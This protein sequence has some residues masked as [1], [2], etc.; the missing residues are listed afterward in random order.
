VKKIEIENIKRMAAEK[1]VAGLVEVLRYGSW[2]R[3]SL[4]LELRWQAA[5]ALGRLGDAR[6]LAPL[7][8]ALQDKN[9]S[10]R[11]NAAEALGEI[12]DS[13]AVPCLIEA[14]GDKDDYPVRCA[15]EALGKLGDETAVEHLVPFLKHDPRSEVTEAAAKSLEKLGW[16][17]KDDEEKA[18][19]L[20]AKRNWDELAKLGKAAVPP[21]IWATEIDTGSL[22]VRAA[23]TLGEI[24]DPRAVKPIIRAWRADWDPSSQFNVKLA[25]YSISD[26]AAV[27]PLIEALRG[28]G[29]SVYGR[30]L[31][32]EALGRI[33][34]S[35]AVG[36]L[37]EALKDEDKD[38][39][40]KAAKALGEIG[41]ARAVGPLVNAIKGDIARTGGCVG[42]LAAAATE[43]LGDIGDESAVPALTEISGV[44]KGTSL[45][46]HV[47]Y[48]LINIERK[49]MGER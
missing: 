5:E 12:G 17:P 28:E 38:L 4:S 27:E 29:V 32:V 18:Y 25:L 19:C 16:E 45:E 11:G 15:V 14:L 10:L 2:Q 49:Q 31:A 21:L 30:W 44:A 13:R 34:D 41:D 37:I 42:E 24:G 46:D 48:A 47:R 35:R 43:A 9:N 20:L 23:I 8:E 1:D 36:P 7:I 6:A 39:C 33:G 22:R 3:P 26:P 40:L